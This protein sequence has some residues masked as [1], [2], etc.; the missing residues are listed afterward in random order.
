MSVPPPFFGVVVLAAGTLYGF[1]AQYQSTKTFQLSIFNTTTN[2]TTT[3]TATG[4]SHQHHHD[5]TTEQRR[6][7]NETS[8]GIYTYT[9]THT[10]IY[11]CI[12]IQS[13]QLFHI[14]YIS[15]H[16]SAHLQLYKWAVPGSSA[17]GI[18]C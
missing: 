7:R 3:T 18:T 1:A 12:H 2:T 10:H 17:S 4:K 9:Y 11:I 15:S 16:T 5:R 14:F 6:T 13:A 8:K